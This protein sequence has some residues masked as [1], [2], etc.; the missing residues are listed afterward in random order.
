MEFPNIGGELGGGTTCFTIDEYSGWIFCGVLTLGLSLNGLTVG[1]RSAVRGLT[2]EKGRAVSY[3]KSKEV[4]GHMQ[5]H[6][7]SVCEWPLFRNS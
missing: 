6:A 4:S 7:Y 2:R 5:S 1:T 3:V